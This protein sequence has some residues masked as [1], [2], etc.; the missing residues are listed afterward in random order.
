MTLPAEVLAA[1]ATEM[2]VEIVTTRPDGSPRRTIIWIV[3]EDG[4]AY[5]RSYRGPDGKW[6][7][8]AL[9]H[10]E[11]TL[12]VRGEAHPVRAVPATDP[13]SVAGCSAGLA[14]KYARDASLSAMLVADV[15][16]T[17]LRLE[18]R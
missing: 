4:V 3:V 5:V 17:T 16:P 14:R 15:L 10:P 6:Y 18:A 12:I 1:C 13:A 2:E 8:E 11:A 7:Q 9:A